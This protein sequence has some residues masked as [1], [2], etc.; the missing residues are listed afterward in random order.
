MDVTYMPSTVDIS[1]AECNPVTCTVSE[2]K[3]L[4]IAKAKAA[5]YTYCEKPCAQV[6]GTVGYD[7][8]V[9]AVIKH[10]P[11][12]FWAGLGVVGN[13]V[14][15]T[16][17]ETSGA[18]MEHEIGHN[19]GFAHGA[20]ANFD[21]ANSFNAQQYPELSRM[22]GGGEVDLKV[23]TTS[24]SKNG[25]FGLCGKVHFGWV[26][27]ANIQKIHPQGA[28]GCSGC[29]QSGTYKLY[30]M[31][32]PGVTP[33]AGKLFGLVLDYVAGGTRPL[34]IYYR[35]SYAATRK[36]VLV[37][38]CTRD[39]QTGLDA[40]ATMQEFTEDA[41]GDT[42]SLEDVAIL[43]GTTFVATPMWNA[44]QDSSVDV[45]MVPR[46]TVTSVT[47]GVAACGAD[48]SSC[49][50]NPDISATVTVDFVDASTSPKA[51]F[52]ATTSTP[53]S[54]SSK[55]F[56]TGQTL[57][58][59]SDGSDLNMKGA[60]GSGNMV[61]DIRPQSEAT[62]YLYDNYPYSA[63]AQKSPAGYNAFFSYP[64]Y[65]FLTCGST[66]S[67]LT[68][69]GYRAV[70]I[71][72]TLDE[73]LSIAEIA[74]S[75][76]Q[77]SCMTNSSCFSYSSNGAGGVS[78]GGT[79]AS[80]KDGT[81][82]NVNDGDVA[83]F[84]H[85][86]TPSRAGAFVVCVFAQPCAATSVK[87]YPRQTQLARS[88]DLKVELWDFAVPEAGATGSV[89]GSQYA[90]GPVPAAR[91]PYLAV[92]SKEYP[93]KHAT[94]A[95]WAQEP[96]TGHK[97]HEQP[98][99]G[100]TWPQTVPCPYTDALKKDLTFVSGQA[101]ALIKLRST[102]GSR[103][104]A[105]GG[106]GG[107]RFLTTDDTVVNFD[108]RATRGSCVAGA[109][110]A[111]STACRK[112]PTEALTVQGGVSK[113]GSV[114]LCSV[115]FVAGESGRTSPA[116]GT[117]SLQSDLKNG[118]NWYKDAAAGRQ[119]FRQTD[120]VDWR[121]TPVANA[122]A[123]LAAET[124]A[125]SP[126]TF[127]GTSDLTGEA[128]GATPQLLVRTVKVIQNQEEALNTA[129]I[130]IW[131]A[132]AT[133]VNLAPSGTC[134]SGPANGGYYLG[135]AATGVTAALNDKDYATFSHSSASTGTTGVAYDMCVLPQAQAISYVNVVPR[136]AWPGRSSSLKVQLWS[137]FTAG[138]S[139]Q[140]TSTYSADANLGTLLAEVT[141]DL[142]KGG[143][144]AVCSAAVQN[145]SA[146]SDPGS[147]SSSGGGTVIVVSGGQRQLPTI[148]ILALL[149]AMALALA[150]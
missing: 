121:I 78:V 37:T 130:E 2:L 38:Y 40:G 138:A 71:V 3:P 107:T 85:S 19:Y 34:Y 35:A 93:V 68:A 148:A 60:G 23:P 63:V 50:A 150:V 9:V 67:S 57:I 42:L 115:V 97:Y 129:E 127:T 51:D 80:S 131:S 27:E 18:V 17:Y 64:V 70:K 82:R 53:L 124:T 41:H 56:E 91:S 6:P 45:T 76:S 15:Y 48:L 119:M 31:D 147:G 10:N 122:S 79:Y 66:G 105:R 118:H 134:Y 7:A 83:T 21:R 132:D 149:A 29:Q 33:T 110:E 113:C 133:P 36:G 16:L 128:T 112:C 12:W 8:L 90:K 89:D 49:P 11:D 104:L 4:T 74:V 73:P 145:P 30:A 54:G 114:R 103:T 75:G 58:R 95:T 141:M 116:D 143:G 81:E 59:V 140:G 88:A 100:T 142:S 101:Y 25:H 46:I 92:L 136:A 43:P 14:C 98:V 87:V 55:L 61:L 69:T 117:Y 126:T 28:T 84:S 13:G 102:S 32:H 5:G 109:Y 26:P 106:Q 139:P 146:F 52:T 65:P 86:S 135:D 125:D 77:G 137:G 39:Y 22:E 72:Q 47:D 111:T 96:G 44:R 144:P 62:V 120:A 20:T 123:V 24:Y 99:G 94:D 108:V 1:D